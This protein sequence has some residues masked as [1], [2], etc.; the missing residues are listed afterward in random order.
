[1]ISAFEK[2]DFIGCLR[3]IFVHSVFKDFFQKLSREAVAYF[4]DLFGSS[5]RDDLSAR[6]AALVTHVYYI[7]GDFDDVEIV[8]DNHDGIAA[9]SQPLK[10]FEK[11]VYVGNVQARS[12]LV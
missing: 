11:L 10:N 3:Q 7:I 4:C 1:M 12:R 5:L 6:V 9:G 2:T 8:L